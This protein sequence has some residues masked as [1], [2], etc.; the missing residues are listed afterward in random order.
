MK[1][2]PEI[3]ARFSGNVTPLSAG[4]I[5]HIR[6]SLCRFPIASSGSWLLLSRK[7]LIE[8]SGSKI[9]RA[10]NH[11]IENFFLQ[12]V[13]HIGKFCRGAPYLLIS[14]S[15]FLSMA[16]K[17][18]TALRLTETHTMAEEVIWID[19]DCG[20]D[21]LGAISLLDEYS[22]R[23]PNKMEIGFIS[24][25]NGMVNPVMA[26]EILGKLFQ[27]DGFYSKPI[28]SC[29]YDSIRTQK[30]YLKESD[31]GPQ[32]KEDFSGFIED[33]LDIYG[34]DFSSKLEQLVIE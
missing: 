1:T 11:R 7:H 32:Y 26:K 20:F 2:V 33:N 21:D 34:D 19:T 3:V 13:M 5:H 12:Q 28:I 25:V 4:I 30:H 14:Q 10:Q 27:S 15:R 31:W 29:G 17:S 22:R 18:S 9:G 23:F 16:T 6:W 24:T 8:G